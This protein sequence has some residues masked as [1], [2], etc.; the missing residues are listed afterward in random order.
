M[1]EAQATSRRG[2]VIGF[3]EKDAVFPQMRLPTGCRWRSRIVEGVAAQALRVLHA[4][5]LEKLYLIGDCRRWTGSERTF[6]RCH[7]VSLLVP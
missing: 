4:K 3:R 1:K 6:Q 2:L 5:A 7:P